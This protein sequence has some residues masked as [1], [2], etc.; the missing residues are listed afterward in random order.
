MSEKFS[1]ELMEC[2]QDLDEWNRFV[3]ASPQ[4]T[5]FS[6]SWWLEAAT[7]GDFQT[8][9]VRD[10]V[11]IAGGMPLV[12]RRVL[13]RTLVGCPPHTFITGPMLREREDLKTYE[14]RLTW[15]MEVLAAL[16]SAIPPVHA[17]ECVCHPALTNWLPFYWQG[18]SQSTAYT[19]VIERIEDVDRVI[20]DMA[21]SKRKNLKRAQAQ[22]KVVENLS[23]DEFYDHHSRSLT[24]EGKVITYTRN[25]LRAIFG[26][27]TSL[28]AGKTWYAVDG[29]G[30][31]HAAIFVVFDAKSAFYLVSSIDPD[32][33]NSGSA[34]LLVLEAIRHVSQFTNRFD[35]EGSMIPG[36]E[37]SF[38][39]LGARQTPYSVITRGSNLRLR[40]SRL[41]ERISRWA[42]LKE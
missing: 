38:R 6:K 35:L 3:E 21:H 12:Q 37:Q 36:V 31:I 23:A 40:F 2:G 41:L 5:L 26:A 14:S 30:A 10:A 33:R 16:V 25:H 19:Y 1:L 32:H 28:R 15:E 34:T 11:G 9:V 4:G 29:Q 24:K 7:G 20:A 27:S 42:G 18:F 13:G 39:R 17:F 22:V 8:L